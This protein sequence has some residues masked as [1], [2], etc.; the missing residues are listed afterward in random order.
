MKRILQNGALVLLGVS[1]ALLIAEATLRLMPWGYWAQKDPLPP[2]YY[3]RADSAAGHDI[4]EH[5]GLAKFPLKDCDLDIWG[6]ELGCFDHPY[7]GEDPF[8]LLVGDSFSWG[9]VPL[10]QHWGKLVEQWTGIR[11]LGCGVPAYGTKN[12][13]LKA[14]RVIEKTS[15]KP[16]AIVLG[17]CV[18]DPIDDYLHPR[19]RVV[20]GYSL[21]ARSIVDFSTGTIQEQTEE[22]LRAKLEIWRDYGVPERPRHPRWER[23]RRI[24]NE[25]SATYRLV[26]PALSDVKAAAVWLL[27]RS[28]G[29]VEEI[30]PAIQYANLP[31]RPEGELPW[32]DKAW[33]DHLA[34]LEA[35]HRW[36]EQSGIRLFV[37]IIPMREQVYPFHPG[38]ESRGGDGP[39]RR[40]R[41]FLEQEKILHVDLQPLFRRHADQRPRRSL[42]SR[43]DL[44]GS[45]DSHWSPRGNRLASLAV[46]SNLIES[47]L[48]EVSDEAGR[49]QA[50]REALETF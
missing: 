16:L 3:F 6:N 15:R 31:F 34:H 9:Y 7:R 11:V 20:D 27:G 14:R 35:L 10:E 33:R 49:L 44:Y 22:A 42:D 39:T 18:N 1:V 40:V 5:A 47:R 8:V 50:I 21:E 48:V 2:Q 36:A 46:A 12:A 24:L 30:S 4:A 13:F 28:V 41:E 25:T 32:L 29:R 19:Y 37:V 43:K 17:Y 45:A 23:F 38:A 26:Q